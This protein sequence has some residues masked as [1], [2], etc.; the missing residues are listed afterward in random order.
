MK[1]GA[2]YIKFFKNSENQILLRDND[3]IGLYAIFENEFGPMAVKDL[4]SILYDC[5]IKVLDYIN[6]VP[7]YFLYGAVSPQKYQNL[8]T[9]EDFYIQEGI[10][11]IGDEAFKCCRD[12]K[13]FHL[14]STLQRIGSYGL[15]SN[16]IEEIHYNGTKAE[17]MQKVTRASNWIRMSKSNF[18]KL[19]F[20]DEVVEL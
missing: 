5:G 13:R 12:I 16:C 1:M 11:N 17:W 14:P 8:I 6:E 20:K 19:V 3:F 18:K 4:T 10:V 15:Q 9:G 7:N 2:Q